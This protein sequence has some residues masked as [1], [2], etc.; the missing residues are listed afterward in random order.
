VKGGTRRLISGSDIGQGKLHAVLDFKDGRNVG[1]YLVP[2]RRG[3]RNIDVL[4]NFIYPGSALCPIHDLV[5]ELYALY[6]QGS[7]AL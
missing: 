4:S 5:L 7:L 1:P 2:G 3:A 6:H